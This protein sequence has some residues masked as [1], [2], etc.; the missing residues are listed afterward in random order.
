[1]P[2]DVGTTLNQY[3]ITGKIGEGGMGAVYSA[4]D[5]Q[6]GRQVALKVL[7]ADLAGDPDR[8][9]RFEREARTVAALNHPN[10]VTLYSVESCDETRFL[11]MELVDGVPLSEV[12]GANGLPVKQFFR[13]A[14]P[15]VEAIAAAHAR[16]ITHRD[17]K[18][19]NI[20]VDRESRVKVL[21][22]GLAKLAQGKGPL[23]QGSDSNLETNVI[24]GVG[25]IVGTVAYMSPEQAEGKPVDARSDIFSLGVV[26]YEMVT[27]EPP[28]S[29]DSPVSVLSAILQLEPKPLSKYRGGLHRQFQ[30]IIDR[31]LAKDPSRRFQ[32]VLDLRNALD[33]LRDELRADELRSD[34][35]S[36]RDLPGPESVPS[37]RAA[38][39]PRKVA[40]LL[41][42][43][44][45]VIIGMVVG[46]AGVAALRR[47][48]SVAL[49]TGGEADAE[50]TLMP[51][52]SFQDVLPGAPTFS[53]DSSEVAYAANQNGQWDLWVVPADGVAARRL[54][55]TE[56]VEADPAYSRDGSLI[57][58]TVTAGSEPGIYLMPAEGGNG[59]L[60]VEQGSRPSWSPDGESIA[61]VRQG[62]IWIASGANYSDRQ[63]VT[64]HLG[65]EPEP[66]WSPTGNALFVYSEI[67][68]DVT[69]FPLD[70]SEPE[71]L[72]LLSPGEQVTSLAVSESAL[73]LARGEFGGH[74][75]LW[76]VPLD[77]RT[78]AVIGPPQRLTSGITDDRE[79][80]VSADGSKIVFL[81]RKLERHLW[82]W[83]LD[84]T[85]G[86]P[87]GAPR[88]LTRSAPLNY[89]P[90][91]SSG[92]D[93]LVWTAH[94]V[95]GLLYQMNLDDG[96]ERK[97][98][99]S[100]GREARE[101]AGVFVPNEEAVIYSSTVEGAYRLFRQ[102]C[103]LCAHIH[104]TQ[105]QNPVADY[106]PTVS[107]DGT[108]L[109]FCS[110]RSGSED[111]WVMSLPDGE[112]R[113]L[114]QLEG[115]E[116][117]PTW[118]PDGRSVLFRS[119]QGAETD[120]WQV[121][122]SGESNP[123]RIVNRGGDQTW[124]QFSP[125]GSRL[126]FVSDESGSYEI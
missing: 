70:G 27:G 3:E 117:F 50:W 118:A 61:Y 15:L 43:A 54:T 109:A 84:E 108:M 67:E 19:T 88:R 34:E 90:A 5:T 59:T 96:S 112:P 120:I 12:V 53:H 18:P 73:I 115:A 98:T 30:R 9:I 122:V 101:I 103:P 66:A 83:T 2:F 25:Q 47:P 104:L 119:I 42:A 93:R 7:P 16:G 60:I 62:E 10:V 123:R 111:I 6:L 79:I 78:D 100:R 17:I 97:L 89:Y 45:L 107:P 65:S 63:R 85:T 21:D 102:D 116:Q 8:L 68:S 39:A 56:T 38:G 113:R 110:N 26:L 95:A 105:P 48:S 74:M 41:S 80:A 92:G 44:A 87:M 106:F 37:R 13:L 20:M 81:A 114:T 40:T 11:T 94:S 52:L 55:D 58:Y 125:D 86:V 72:N 29:G 71:P 77:P 14:L 35:L 126:Y 49:P 124:A 1:M 76:R 23:L 46:G 51:L 99:N 31:C 82:A 91:L 75:T 4:E 69:R 22:F 28:F 36:L 57:A 32:T 24:T 64:G 121:G 33:A